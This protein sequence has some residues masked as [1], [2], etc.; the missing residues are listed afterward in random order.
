MTR[1][2]LGKGQE[3][4]RRAMGKQRL[5]I[6]QCSSL[7]LRQVL[8]IQFTRGRPYKKDD[9]AHMEQKNWTHVR[10][11][12]GYERYDSPTGLEALNNLYSHPRGCF[13][14]CSFPR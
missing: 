12:L 8:E 1:A 6:Y 10:R 14:T 4:V 11:L 7:S 13:K 2:V 9:N 3:G 5:G